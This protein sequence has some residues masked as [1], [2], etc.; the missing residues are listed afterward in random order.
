[1]TCEYKYDG[2]RAQVL[3]L[4][5]LPSTKVQILTQKACSSFLSGGSSSP[6]GASMSAGG[7]SESAR[8]ARSRSSMTRDQAW[9]AAAAAAAAG[10][11]AL[12]GDAWDDEDSDDYTRGFLEMRYDAAPVC[13]P[14]SMSV[15]L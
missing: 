14:F 5:A 1:M 6:G 10:K 9:S 8:G 15:S 4:L 12:G 7:A 2:E 13:L 3:S 11:S